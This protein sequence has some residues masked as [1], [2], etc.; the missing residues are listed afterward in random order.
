MFRFVR[1]CVTLSLRLRSAQNNVKTQYVQ[2]TLNEIEN[3][4]NRTFARLKQAWI[5][6]R[7]LGGQY[8]LYQTILDQRP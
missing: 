2:S 6:E 1:D 8:V 7:N 4:F 5:K 3:T